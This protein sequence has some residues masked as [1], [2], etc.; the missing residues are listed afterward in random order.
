MVLWI[1]FNNCNFINGNIVINRI[2][3]IMAKQ[4]GADANYRTECDRI[5]RCN[6]ENI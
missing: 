5:F 3:Q 4:G 6:K 2:L 1:N